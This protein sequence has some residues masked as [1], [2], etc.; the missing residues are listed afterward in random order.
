MQGSRETQE[1]QQGKRMPV[2][3]RRVSGDGDHEDEVHE[4]TF[5]CSPS[6]S[7]P[8]PRLQTASSS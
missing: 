4:M 1:T 8:L 6:F 5:A 2:C 3:T 7:L